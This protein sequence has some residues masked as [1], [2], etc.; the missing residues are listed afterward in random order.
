MRHLRA[1]WWRGVVLTVGVAILALACFGLVSGNP[2][3]Q[4]YIALGAVGIVAALLSQYER[5]S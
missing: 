2:D 3:Q 5:T 1:R 4:F